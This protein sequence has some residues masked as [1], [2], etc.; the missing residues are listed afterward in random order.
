MKT[1][2]FL[3]YR[4][5]LAMD[6]QARERKI[7]MCLGVGRDLQGCGQAQASLFLNDLVGKLAHEAATDALIDHRPRPVWVGNV[8]VHAMAVAVMMVMPVIMVVMVAVTPCLIIIR[9]AV[10]CV[11]V[12]H[13]HLS[14]REPFFEGGHEITIVGHLT[15]FGLGDPLHKRINHV[16]LI[17]EVMRLEEG[18]VR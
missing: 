6:R 17:R 4:T 8:P 7:R 10:F 13:I 11:V 1:S 15:G 5:S 16:C 2:F 3:G 14:A 18:H 9:I 12:M